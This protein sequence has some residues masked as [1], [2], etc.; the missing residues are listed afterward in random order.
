MAPLRDNTAE[1]A[2]IWNNFKP[3]E[4]QRLVNAMPKRIKS[5]LKRNDDV[6]QW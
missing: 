5:V 4:Y 6:P 3:Q 1:Y 2:N